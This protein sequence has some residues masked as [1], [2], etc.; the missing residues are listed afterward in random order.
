MGIDLRENLSGG[1]LVTRFTDGTAPNRWLKSVTASD[2]D[3]IPDRIL[4]VG[5]CGSQFA[6][7][8]DWAGASE[9]DYADFAIPKDMVAALNEWANARFDSEVSYPHNF[10]RLATAR[11]YIRRFVRDSRDLQLLGIGVHR[12]DLDKLEAVN[13]LN[14]SR[15][16]S[17][18]ASIAGFMEGGFGRAIALAEPPVPGETLGFD[19]IACRYQIDHSWHCNALAKE[20]L[21]QFGFRPNRVGLIDE[22]ANA[23]QL[24]RYATEQCIEDSIWL[25][26]LVT[27]YPTVV[28]AF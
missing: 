27:R 13:K 5:F 4:S 14:P 8:F 26:V 1:Y 20:A 25:A 18:G 12:A 6:P 11:E 3:L 9:Q 28:D 2:T 23:D 7:I 22:K 17:S 16:D 24:A 10:F 19:V 15:I 21:E